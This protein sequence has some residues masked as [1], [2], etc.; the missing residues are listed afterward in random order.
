MAKKLK[1]SIHEQR[2]QQ[3]HKNQLSRCDHALRAHC[4]VIAKFMT[5]PFLMDVRAVLQHA[6]RDET[7]YFSPARE[8]AFPLS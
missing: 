3:Q 5:L 7:F 1:E 2:Q 8:R 4:A 6:A